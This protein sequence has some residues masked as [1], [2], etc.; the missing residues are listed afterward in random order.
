M[1]KLC[2]KCKTEPRTDDRRDGL[3]RAC[4]R[5]YQREYHRK[6]NQAIREGT[7]QHSQRDYVRHGLTGTLTYDKWRGLMTR[8]SAITL[9]EVQQAID[10]FQNVCDICDDPLTLSEANFDHCH[11]TDKF[12]GWLCRNCN[13]GVGM[14][15]NRPELFLAAMHYIIRKY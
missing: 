13:V 3:C 8:G 11:D 12:R 10:Q 6:R 9:D 4:R 7:W 5:T 1:G 2:S 15:R 14:F